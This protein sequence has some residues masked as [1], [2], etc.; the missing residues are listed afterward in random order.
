M[1]H[2]NTSVGVTPA[3]VHFGRV[4]ERVAERQAVLD[5]AFALDPERFP[6]FIEQR[7]VWQAPSRVSLR[8][9]GNLGAPPCRINTSLNSLACAGSISIG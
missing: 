7:C 2:P 1:S 5:A 3:D 6:N 8:W 4:D 9:S